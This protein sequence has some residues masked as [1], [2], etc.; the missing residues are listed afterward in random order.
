MLRTILVGVDGTASG[1]MALEL[2]L[3]W[4][5]RAEAMVVGLGIVDEPGLH[6]PEEYLI[7]ERFFAPVNTA[8][9][10]ESQHRVV[11]LLDRCTLRCVERGV[12]FKPLE[13]VGAP[14]EVILNESQRFDVIVLG[15]ETHFRQGWDTTPD[16]TFE[17]VLAGS[18]RPVVGVAP[19][20]PES[21]PILVAYDGSVQ[22]ARA[23]S[24]FVATGLGEHEAVHILSVG[25]IHRDAALIAERAHDYLSSHRRH[26]E[27][28]VVETTRSP[29]EVILETAHE[30]RYSL[31]VMGA[32]GQPR[33]REVLLGSTTRS[34]LRQAGCPVFLDH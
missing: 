9:L 24:S 27:A 31:V 28:R 33:I 19:N 17:R 4:A 23:L 14:H 10:K 25:K 22:A 18:A 7:G 21:G 11:R 12:A 8:L 16:D 15:L 1:E 32:L 3:R 26:A 2:A 5:T 20:P 6:G 29:A 34:V 30:G 13:V